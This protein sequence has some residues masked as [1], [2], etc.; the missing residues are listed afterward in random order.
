V[1][2]NSLIFQFLGTMLDHRPNREHPRTIEALGK[3]ALPS[4]LDESF[5]SIILGKIPILGLKKPV[6]DLPIEFCELLI[7]LWSRCLDE[8]YVCTYLSLLTCLN[9]HF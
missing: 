4:A 8:T 9:Q 5:E 3:H 7:S 6:T 2:E 1:K